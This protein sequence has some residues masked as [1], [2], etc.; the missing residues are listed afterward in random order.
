MLWVCNRCTTKYAVG[1]PYCPQCTSTDKRE[2]GAVAKTT[3]HGGAS[4][5]DAERPDEL[6]PSAPASASDLNPADEV[7]QDSTSTPDTEHY[8]DLTVVELRQLIRIRN[9]DRDEDAQLALS[10]SKQELVERLVA[11]DKEAD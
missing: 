5:T 8:Q 4:Y 11:D 10:G 2:D 3:Q 9:S 6:A 7:G 1:L